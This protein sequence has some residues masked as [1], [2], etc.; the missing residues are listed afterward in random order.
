MNVLKIC[1][2]PIFLRFSGFFYD[3]PDFL[4]IFQH[5]SVFSCIFPSFPN[6]PE[7]S[8]NFPGFSAIFHNFS[9]FPRMLFRLKQNFPKA[10]SRGHVTLCYNSQPVLARPHV[11]PIPDLGFK[12][13]VSAISWPFI[14]RF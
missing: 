4:L 5:F 13:F 11:K 3:F 10:S 12:I 1:N 14:N 7:F 8:H 6:F 2:F 9:D